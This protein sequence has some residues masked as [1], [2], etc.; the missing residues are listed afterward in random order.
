[1]TYLK[2]LIALTTLALLTACAG[3]VAITNNTTIIPSASICA[4][5][6]F[7]IGCTTTPAEQATFCRDKTK[8]T[9]TKDSDCADTVI[10]VCTGD[11]FDT[12]C[13]TAPTETEAEVF[14]RD[15][16]KSPDGKTTNCTPTVMRVCGENPYDAGLCIDNNSY[17]GPRARIELTCENANDAERHALCPT[18]VATECTTN[19]F[20]AVCR[21]GTAGAGAYNTARLTAIADC[22]DASKRDAIASEICA[23]ATTQACGENPYNAGLCYDGTT[24]DSARGRIRLTCTNDN[25]A[26]RN[27]LCP[28][29]VATECTMDPFLDVCRLGTAGAETGTYGL[30]RAAQILATCPTNVH[31]EICHNVDPYEGQR[32]GILSN[33]E[34]NVGTDN[35]CPADVVMNVCLGNPYNAILCFDPAI[36]YNTQRMERLMAC[37]GTNT[38]AGCAEAAETTCPANPFQAVLCFIENTY[39][40]TRASQTQTCRGMPNEANCGAARAL[41]CDTSATGVDSVLFTDTLCSAHM[42]YDGDRERICLNNKVESACMTTVMRVCDANNFDPL[43]DES[44]TYQN[45]R[46]ST[47]TDP[48]EGR[49]GK[50]TLRICNADKFDT[51]C[52]GATAFIADQLSECAEATATTAQC[53][54]VFT[55][56]LAG[57][58]TDPF[59]VACDTEAT[60][61]DSKVAVRTSRYNFCATDQTSDARCAGYRTCNNNLVF[62]PLTCG[63]DFQP[64]RMA[65]CMTTANAFDPLC[66][67]N[68]LTDATAQLEYCKLST[69][70]LFGTDCK[71]DAFTQARIEFCMDTP[72]N[73][74]CRADLLGE[75]LMSVTDPCA[76]GAC[77]DVADLPTY[78]T[79][80]EEKS[81]TAGDAFAHGALNV[82][83]IAP[84]DGVLL[85]PNG[86]ENSTIDTTNFPA[87]TR[88]EKKSLRFGRRG[89]RGSSD[90]DGFVLFTILKGAIGTESSQ[91]SNHATILPTTNLGAPLASPL[92]TALWPGHFYTAANTYST[93]FYVT[94]DG[95]TGAIGFANPTKDGI[96]TGADRPTFAKT[97]GI[98]L[99]DIT[100]GADGVLSGNIIPAHFVPAQP[101]TGLIGQEGAVGV[102]VGESNVSAGFTATNPDGGAIPVVDACIADPD[103]CF[104]TYKNWVDATSVTRIGIPTENTFTITSNRRLLTSSSGFTNNVTNLDTAQFGGVALGGDVDNG[105]IVASVSLSFYLAGIRS[106]TNLGLPLEAQPTGT[107]NGSFQVYER[108]NNN[109]VDSDDFTLTVTYGGSNL[110]SGKTGSISA[111]I[112]NTDYSF[113]GEFNASGVID[114]TVTHTDAMN[115]NSTAELQG[116]IGA[117]GAVGVFI[118]NADTPLIY[119]GGFVAC[120]YN[121]TTNKCTTSR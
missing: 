33:C 16:S 36:D 88:L 87:T 85:N 21:L 47:C 65:F 63:A 45:L 81:P 14:C 13:P 38:L 52:M 22:G 23:D 6:P 26:M 42:D 59:S 18:A 95:T 98:A 74:D 46:R 78:P 56:N 28:T 55:G 112:A 70:N 77:V 111:T 67:N 60:F 31:D 2:T 53:N 57:C 17:D 75:N 61:M 92:T 58:L 96:G 68:N 19:P 54:M 64:V 117:R 40:G 84:T 8:T 62:A 37:R 25:D 11:V 5:N 12:I 119:G 35:A 115:G 100:F 50:T 69:A 32:Q 49:C 91:R 118:N 43:C 89:G 51:Y 41:G 15:A 30:E 10:R 103:T 24:Y 105:F 94:F 101:T 79:L 1:M 82:T 9:N 121:T 7:T 34:T 106:T 39:A 116:L 102:L 29:A 97:T 99:Q 71:K 110:G 90:A 93:D 27:A 3:G 73:N 86:T 76:G 120:P 108:A 83:F 66:V 4:A 48:N 20:N 107:W 80:P 72:D 109:P 104:V 114:G 113:V 44:M